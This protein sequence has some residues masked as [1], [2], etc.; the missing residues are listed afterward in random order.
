MKLIVVIKPVN[1]VY[2]LLRIG[3][4]PT[5]LEFSFY[6]LETWQPHYIRESLF[7]QFTISGQT[8]T[9]NSSFIVLQKIKDDF[10]F[11]GTVLVEKMN[12]SQIMGD[13]HP[14]I[15]FFDMQTVLARFLY[16]NFGIQAAMGSRRWP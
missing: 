2:N 10:L 15:T 16:E 7:P 12:Q 14:D 11:S 8:V 6:M 13:R 1:E 9:L 4:F 5:I 3:I